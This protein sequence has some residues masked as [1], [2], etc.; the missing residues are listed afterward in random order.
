MVKRLPK[1]LDTVYGE[2]TSFSGWQVQLF[3]IARIILQQRSLIIFDEGTNQLDAEHEAMIINILKDLKKDHAIFIITH[4]MTT[5]RHADQIYVMDEGK[6]V[7]CGK[8]QELLQKDNIYKKFWELQ[9]V[10]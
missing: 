9:V 8:H 2:E 1:G 6:I 4:K 3:A 5:A 10:S 7:E